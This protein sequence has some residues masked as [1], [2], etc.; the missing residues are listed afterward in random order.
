MSQTANATVRFDDGSVNWRQLGEFEHFRY[1]VIAVDE[2]N[3]IADF[4]LRFEPG[5]RIFLH[6][7][8]AHTNTIV[9][10]GEHRIYEPGGP[11]KEV[12][13]LGSFTSAPA[14]DEP[15]AE[16]GGGDGAVVIYNTRGS[17]GGVVFDVLD[18]AQNVVGTLSVA[19]LAALFAA[20]GGQPG[21]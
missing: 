18:D 17:A 10:Q 8:R 11:L 14:A 13:P 16:G 9:V 1:T 2:A 20:Q 7:H 12:R 6:R 21:A 15:H 5:E 4:M 19:D 3:E